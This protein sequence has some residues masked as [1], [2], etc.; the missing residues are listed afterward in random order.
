ML[1]LTGDRSSIVWTERPSF[2]YALAEMDPLLAGIE[3]ER[4]FGL[5]LGRITVEGALQAYPLRRM[6]VRDWHAGRLVLAGDAAHVFHPLAG[7]GLNMGLRDVAALA[8]VVA[9]A[10]RR[11]EDIGDI[12]VLR[13]YERWRRFDNVSLALG[14]DALARL[15]SNASPVLMGLRDAGLA[16]VDR[17]PALKRF[18][19]REAAGLSG[20]MPAMLRGR[21]P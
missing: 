1:P 3:I 20:E 11:G 5:S 19:M 21:M 13:R 6:L 16:A 15:F 14:M 2:A 7:Q 4:V 9:T 17:L 18:F 10:A 8:E 12:V